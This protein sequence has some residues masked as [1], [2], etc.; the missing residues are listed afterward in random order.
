VIKVEGRWTGRGEGERESGRW[1]GEER[2]EGIDKGLKKGKISLAVKIIL[3]IGKNLAMESFKPVDIY[4]IR[5]LETLKVVSDPLRAQIYEVLI[6]EALT[7]NQ[8][9]EKLGLAASRLYY[10]VNLL[11]KHG[12]IQVVETQMISNL[13]EK[14]YRAV[15][16]NLEVD[17]ALFSFSSQEGK[18]NINTMV[19]ATIDSTREDLL[20]SLAARTFELERGAEEH[21]RRVIITRQTSKIPGER[22]AQFQERLKALI[23]EFGDANVESSENSQ[24]L[25]TYALMV[26][27]YPSFYFRNSEGAAR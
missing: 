10:H 25:Q 5:D 7:V 21:P 24:D 23:E 11:E 18:E 16:S 17:H 13:V 15:A 3:A 22:A 19:T 2:E 4:E 14:Y 1:T 26:T 12:L 9:G 27:F 8:I 6:P 20:R